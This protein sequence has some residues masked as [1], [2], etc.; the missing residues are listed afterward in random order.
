[1]IELIFVIVILGIL[2]AVALPRF[3]GVQ[4]DALV[5]SE[6]TGIAA[7]RTGITAIRGRALVRG[8]T[9]ADINLT[10]Y[11]EQGA[12]Y[13]LNI[14]R[15]AGTT[16]D[17]ETISSSGFPNGLSGDGWGATIKTQQDSTS[18]S[19]DEGSTALVTVLEPG[20]RGTYRTF[21][22]DADGNK[23]VIIGP[24]TGGVTASDVELCQGKWW[25]Y[26]PF[27]GTMTQQGTCNGG[28]GPAGSADGTNSNP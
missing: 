5:S 3:T 14:G 6:K 13:R 18:G 23:S 9:E 2:A 24:A 10:V 27:G 21:G 26:E 1:M 4:D 12:Q 8:P 16:F 17:E 15:N 20:N 19:N 28:T 22:S 7:V 25:R 11:D